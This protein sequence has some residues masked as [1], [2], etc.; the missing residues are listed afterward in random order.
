MAVCWAFIKDAH[1]QRF[2]VVSK[3]DD[4]NRE[5]FANT[6]PQYNADSFFNIETFSSQFSLRIRD[7]R[8]LCQTSAHRLLNSS[9]R[10]SSKNLSRRTCVRRLSLCASCC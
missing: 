5:K 10:T 8:K 6:D 9:F 3:S 2:G 4:S 1:Q 7:A